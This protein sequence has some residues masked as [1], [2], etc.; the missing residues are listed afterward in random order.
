MAIG[1]VATAL[2][3]VVNPKFYRRDSEAASRYIQVTSEAELRPS[4]LVRGARGRDDVTALFVVSGLAR[5]R[6]GGAAGRRQDTCGSHIGPSRRARP[7][8]GRASTWT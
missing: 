7:G 2:L 5:A 6:I 8:V 1:L 3:Y 4:V